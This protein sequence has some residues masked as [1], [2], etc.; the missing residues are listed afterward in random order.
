MN[1][2]GVSTTGVTIALVVAALAVPS[3]LYVGLYLEHQDRIVPVRES[4]GTRWAAHQANPW[5]LLENLLQQ[6][7]VY[8]TMVAFIAA[9]ALGI[10]LHYA[11]Q[12]QRLNAQAWVKFRV[13]VE[14]LVAIA[15]CLSLPIALAALSGGGVAPLFLAMTVVSAA[16]GMVLVFAVANGLVRR[17][18]QERSN[19]PLPLLLVIGGLA[20]L[21]V[22]L[23]LTLLM[24]LFAGSGPG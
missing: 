15:Y 9:V 22:L 4:Y 6:T 20:N 17:R 23:A 11:T 16:L 14:A 18:L 2:T 12:P 3:A 1:R 24:A 8:G 19:P 13:S 5:R 21:P 10:G 7:L